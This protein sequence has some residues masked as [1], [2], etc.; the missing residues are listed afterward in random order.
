MVGGRQRREKVGCVCVGGGG[1]GFMP[2]A[3]PA[4]SACP[5]LKCHLEGRADGREAG[6]AGAAER[7]GTLGIGSHAS[8]ILHGLPSISVHT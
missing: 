1:A 8:L 3:R 7:S 4:A 5:A 6:R 2:T